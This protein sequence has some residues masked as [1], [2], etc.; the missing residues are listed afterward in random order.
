MQLSSSARPIHKLTASQLYT[1]WLSKSTVP[2]GATSAAA[3]LFKIAGVIYVV[4]SKYGYGIAH[5][6][7]PDDVPTVIVSTPAVCDHW[8]EQ[9][10]R[11]A[12][13]FSR[14]AELGARLADLHEVEGSLIVV[15][16]CF[17][18]VRASANGSRSPKLQ[19][20]ASPLHEKRQTHCRDVGPGQ[21]AR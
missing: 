8:G 16:D 10:H 13:G 15:G 21:G 7:N 5:Q 3:K 11:E 14:A 12:T 4:A 2:H 6:F 17:P 9:A 19:E 20:M 1:F 18:V